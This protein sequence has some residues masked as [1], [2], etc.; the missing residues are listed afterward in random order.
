MARPGL[1]LM[2]EFGC[3]MDFLTPDQIVALEPSLAAYKPR[4]AAAAHAPEDE[5]GDAFQFTQKLAALAAAQGVE[6]RYGTHVVSLKSNGDRIAGV[7]V[8]PGHPNGP[9]REETLLADAYLGCLG[10]WAA[11]LLRKVG[12]STL[13]YPAKG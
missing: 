8:K 7:V 2:R 3:T 12:G 9:G 5:S 6:F 10:P 13:I 4:L 11:H 1:E